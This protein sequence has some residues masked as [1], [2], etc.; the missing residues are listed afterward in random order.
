[1]PDQLFV[2]FDNA[3]KDRAVAQV[4]VRNTGSSAAQVSISQG[5]WDRA[6]NG[7]NQFL[8]LNSTAGSCGKL[9]SVFPLSL[10]LEPNATGTIRITYAGTASLAS[11][12][13]NAVILEPLPQRTV[14]AG[15]A[16]RYVMRSAVKVYVVPPGA[17][18]EGAIA[19]MQF[20]HTPNRSLSIAFRNLGGA[21]LYTRGR[22]EFR[23]ADNVVAAEV[24]V[25]EFPTL[26]GAQRKIL[27][28]VP[29]LARGR[30]VAIVLLDFGGS[31][32]AAGELEI[33][34]R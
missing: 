6:E 12:C 33:D 31:E 19:D 1:M 11:E 4:V 14:V 2:T 18:R 34:V 9:L 26:P 5:D 32:I 24:P 22:A 29:K 25:A 17:R 3:G 23:T 27:V 8:P 20:V 16:L 21:H 7:D 30:Y 13:W 15:S 28:K 10:R